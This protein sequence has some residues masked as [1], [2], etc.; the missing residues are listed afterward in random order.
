[1]KGIVE[2]FR[3]KVLELNDIVWC[4]SIRSWGNSVLQYMSCV[5]GVL[6]RYASYA[7]QVRIL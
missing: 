6:V 3:G 7:N 4:Y 2:C 1:M 5:L